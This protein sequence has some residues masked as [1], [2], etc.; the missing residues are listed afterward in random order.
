[1]TDGTAVMDETRR[2]VEHGGVGNLFQRL[3]DRSGDRS[4]VRAVFGKP[5]TRGEV[6]VVPV[7]R[8]RWLFG[9]AQQERSGSGRLGREGHDGGGGPIAG[10]EG[11]GEAQGAGFGGGGATTAVPV[12]YIEI[13]PSGASFKPIVD[14]YPSPVFMIAAGVTTAFILRGLARLIRG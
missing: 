5:I 10:L 6:T 13:G 4:G 14:P 7:A 1:M 3:A 9:A 12:G 2:S 11:E 8:V